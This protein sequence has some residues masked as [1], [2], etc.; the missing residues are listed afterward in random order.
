MYIKRLKHLEVIKFESM[1]FVH[2]KLFKIM[3][4]AW[5][6]F[7]KITKF[8]MGWFPYFN[9][10][11]SLKT[12]LHMF[13]LALILN[14][15]ILLFLKMRCGNWFNWLWENDYGEIF[16][17]GSRSG[18]SCWVWY[19]ITTKSLYLLVPCLFFSLLIVYVFHTYVVLHSPCSN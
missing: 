3:D 1:C 17:D 18:C 7:S 10:V 9:I 11:W 16:K 15:I 14:K 2:Q 8:K 13:I 19:W 5:C 4:Q 6:H 12:R